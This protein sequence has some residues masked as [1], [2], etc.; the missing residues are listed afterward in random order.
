MASGGYGRP[1]FKLRVQAPNFTFPPP[2]PIRGSTTVKLSCLLGLTFPDFDLTPEPN[3][4]CGY[5]E[6]DLVYSAGEYA[7]LHDLAFVGAEKLTEIYITL[8][9]SLH[10]LIQI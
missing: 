5:S 2:L 10:E 6:L 9:Y 4:K 3:E 8:H 1:W 7:G